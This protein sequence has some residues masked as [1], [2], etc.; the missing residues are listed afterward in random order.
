[1]GSESLIGDLEKKFPGELFEAS[2]DGE[3]FVLVI[4]PEALLRIMG[5]LK[6]PP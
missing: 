1:M 3:D 5:S 6:E 4:F 2:G